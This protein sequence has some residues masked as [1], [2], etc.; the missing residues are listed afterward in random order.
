LDFSPLLYRNIVEGW[1]CGSLD[2]YLPITHKTMDS[3]LSTA[4]QKK[5]K[6]KRKKTESGGS[7]GRGGPNNVYTCK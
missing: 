6:K 2:E 4:P 7:E 3:I 5:K 1:G